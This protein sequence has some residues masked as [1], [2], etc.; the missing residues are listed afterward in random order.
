L[1]SKGVGFDSPAEVFISDDDLAEVSWMRTLEPTS[2]VLGCLRAKSDGGRAHS[3]GAEVLEGEGDEGVVVDFP[4]TN[5]HH[6]VGDG[7][8]AFEIDWSSRVIE[9]IFS[10]VK[11]WCDRGLCLEGECILNHSIDM[12]R[13]G[14]HVLGKATAHNSLI[15]IG[16][17][18]LS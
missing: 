2:W 11:G 15:L 18:L 12:R 6:A 17:L 14:V 16:L 1:V 8:I 3:S 13:N 10:W 5:K 4:C 9:V 7:A